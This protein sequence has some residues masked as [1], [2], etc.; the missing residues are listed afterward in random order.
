MKLIKKI[1]T[2]GF[3]KTCRDIYEYQIDECI[4]KALKVILRN[5]PLKNIIV[6]ESH[7]DFDCNGGAFYDFLIENE[8]NKKYKIVWLLKHPDKKP[9]KL[10][11]NVECVSL[12]KPSIKKDYY[13]VIAK[14]FTS[15]NYN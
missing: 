4:I 14:Y 6:I 8:Y 13:N 2:D 5:K 3:C 12:F 9:G 15:D 7:N 1:R 11:S 10:P